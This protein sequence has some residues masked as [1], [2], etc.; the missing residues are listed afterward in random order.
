M[1]SN[2]NGGIVPSLIKFNFWEVLGLSN[3]KVFNFSNEH[4]EDLFILILN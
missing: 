1:N 2:K 4:F 3:K